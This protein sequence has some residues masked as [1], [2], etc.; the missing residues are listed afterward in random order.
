M[1]ALT[2]CNCV[3]KIKDQLGNPYGAVGGTVS[4]S[5]AELSFYPRRS[6]VNSSDALYI[7]KTQRSTA[8]P[9]VVV[10]DLLYIAVATPSSVP[11]IT[12]TGGGTAGNEVVTVNG[13]DIS[14][15]IQSGVSTATQV[16]AAFD[17]S[18]AAVA[19]AYCIVSG[20]GSTAQTTA[21][22]T[23]FSSEYCYL[24]LSE[25]T[26]NS[27]SGIFQLKW[28]DGSNYDS[29]MFDPVKIPNQSFQDLSS[30]LTV[31]RG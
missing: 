22:S 15:Q 5:A 30:L 24:P 19:V 3:L 25:T 26:T 9:G 12:Y 8:Q 23:S 21:S 6:Q 20:T 13:N 10:Q 14:I 27:Q 28:T 16:K 7:S 18:A 2:I 31:S 4:T 29:V 11:T 17:A 1:S